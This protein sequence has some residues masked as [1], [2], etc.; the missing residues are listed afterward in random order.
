MK[1]LSIIG[2]FDTNNSKENIVANKPTKQQNMFA[3]MMT[4]LNTQTLQQE[5]M[6]RELQSVRH[7]L[8]QASK[9]LAQKDQLIGSLELD[10]EHMIDQMVKIQQEHNTL[11][12]RQWI[13]RTAPGLAAESNAMAIS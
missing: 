5:L 11:M 4:Q 6:Q 13:T 7:K 2:I 12:E 1:S 10:L 9:T 3:V 8:E